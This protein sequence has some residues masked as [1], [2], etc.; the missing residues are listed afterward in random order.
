MAGYDNLPHIIWQ[1][2]TLFGDVVTKCQQVLNWHYFCCSQDINLHEK[3]SFG[4]KKSVMTCPSL[5]QMLLSDTIVVLQKI[6]SLKR[7]PRMS[8]TSVNITHIYLYWLIHLQTISQW[9][10]SDVRSFR[11][12]SLII[13]GNGPIISIINGQSATENLFWFLFLCE[14]IFIF[15]ISVFLFHLSESN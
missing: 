11:M 15:Q 2:T 3:Y 10:C 12:V 4:I 8:E 6:T 7:A 14:C 1:Y 5:F 13:A 9:H